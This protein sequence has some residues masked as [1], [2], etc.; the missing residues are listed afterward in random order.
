MTFAQDTKNKGLRLCYAIIMA[1]TAI[2]SEPACAQDYPSRPI[3][4]LVGASPGGTTDIV[5]RLVAHEL[6][7]RLNQPVAVENRPGAGGN[8]ALNAVVGA[9]PDGY[10]LGMAYSGLAINP[11][12][13]KKMPF[14]TLNDLAPVSL[15]ATVDMFLLVNPS[16]GVD[17]VQDLV[18]AAKTHPE[19]ITLAANALGSV[20]HLSA[21]LLKLRTG[22][23]SPIAVYKGSAPALIDLMAG[24]IS[25][26]FD[27]VPGALN[28]VKQGRLKVIASGG[29]H[30]LSIAPDVPTL[31]ESGLEDFR[32]GSWYGLVAP[33]GTP[34]EVTNTLSS[35]IIDVLSAPQIKQ[36]LMEQ[37]LNPKGTTPAEFKSFISTEMKQ[38]EKVAKD[39]HI[40]IR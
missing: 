30:R 26:M 32:I 38:W 17:T 25:A 16:L 8:L 6:E 36:Q 28:Y 14:D 2:I 9:A 20:S 24:N 13:M 27:T 29:A 10:T 1:A 4:M 7:K 12:V 22:M 5:A 15:V 3:R 18:D 35:V 11:A 19:K 23:E 39:A 40:T 31:E 33:A 21:A 34:A 37:M